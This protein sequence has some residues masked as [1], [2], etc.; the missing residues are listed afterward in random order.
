MSRAV[1]VT[2]AAGQAELAAD[3]LWSLG[4]LAIEERCVADDA[5]E[6]W[7]SVG[8]EPAAIAAARARL[9]PAWGWRVEEVDDS[10]AERWRDFATPTIVDDDL[11]IVPAWWEGPLPPGRIVRID[12]GT[13]F[14]MGDHP[15][16]RL[17]LSAMRRVLTPGAT[18]LDVG[19]GSGVLGIVACL[20]GAATALGIDIADPAIT[21]AT[22]NAVANGVGDR[23]RARRTPLAEIG[24]RFDVVVANILAPT[25]IDLAAD[26]R[27]VTSGHLVISGVLAG[28]FDHV[29]AALAPMSVVAV[30]E[31]LGWAAVT[32]SPSAG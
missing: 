10:V 24:R 13:S 2:V 30:D 4:V 6:L 14:G 16:T 23:C 9:D 17:T 29:V 7:S 31:Q 3:V 19:C 27:R 12:P 22:A 28:R 21:A 26:L 1:V 18:V 32:L 20:E 8:D 15:T 11:A 5:V 25:L